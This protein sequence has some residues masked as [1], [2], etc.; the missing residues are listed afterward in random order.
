MMFYQHFMFIQIKGLEACEQVQIL[1]T[2]SNNANTSYIQLDSNSLLSNCVS[3]INLFD[4]FTVPIAIDHTVS[5]YLVESINHNWAVHSLIDGKTYGQTVVNYSSYMN[6][7]DQQQNHYV[8]ERFEEQIYVSLQHS[9]DSL[10]DTTLIL[11]AKHFNSNISNIKPNSS[12][13]PK[14]TIASLK[15]SN[16]IKFTTA[17]SNV[18]TNALSIIKLLHTHML[19]AFHNFDQNYLKQLLMLF[20]NVNK[21]HVDIERFITKI[22]VKKVQNIIK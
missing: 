5:K 1:I 9:T 8:T 2:L 19:D 13:I 12:F 21:C 22:N 18:E 15:C 16:L 17:V 20:N 3:C 7:D 11:N 6:N 14:Q 4:H 10:S